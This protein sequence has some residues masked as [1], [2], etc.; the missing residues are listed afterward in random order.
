MEG[1]VFNTNN[2]GTCVV[3]D[4]QNYDNVL[5]RFIETGYTT[6]TSK[7]N[8][9]RGKVKD[10]LSPSIYGQGV[11]GENFKLDESKSQCFQLWKNMLKRCYSKAS[12]QDSPTYKECYVSDNFKYFTYFKDWCSNQIGFN[13]EGFELDKDILIKGNKLYSEDTCC[14]VP[15]EINLLLVKHD[16]GRGSFALGV[17]YHK[18]RKQFRARCGNKHLGWFSTEQDAF[19]AYKEAK[20]DYIK[21]L[22]NKWKD[23]ID[24]RVYD[25][26]LRYEVE[27]TD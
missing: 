23:Q 17:D 16:K 21:S 11:I 3:M 5:V 12:I 15:K 27:I 10:Y 14:F 8:L 24:P 9:V 6:L 25:A 19:Q 1:K 22:A 20:E 2:S 26:L 4:Y 18:T 13:V 7:D